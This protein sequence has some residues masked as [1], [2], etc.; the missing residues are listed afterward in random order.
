[1]EQ[2]R[3]KSPVFWASLTAQLVSLMA[4]LGVFVRLGVASEV[5]EQTVAMLLQ[6]LVVFGVLNNPTNKEGF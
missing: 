1:M 4:F 3:M 5:V 2:N 6:M